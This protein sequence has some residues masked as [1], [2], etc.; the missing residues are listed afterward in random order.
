MLNINWDIARK[1]GFRLLALDLFMLS[2]ALIN[3]LL[4]AFDFT[5][6]KFRNFYYH[7]IPIAIHYDVVKGIE[8][9][10]TTVNY[11]KEAD[12]F[13]ISVKND[14]S[15]LI[16]A[17]SEMI[18]FSNQL[19]DEQPFGR[20][21]KVGEFELVKERM[22]K[23]VNI[24]SSKAAFMLFWSSTTIDNID[25]RKNFFDTKIKRVLETNYWRGIDYSGNYIDY[26]FYIDGI[27][28]FI[29]LIEFMTMWIYSVKIKG[30]EEKIL[31]PIYH[32]HDLLGCIPLNSFRILRLLRVVTIF[33]RLVNEGVISRDSL[34]YTSI[35]HRINKYKEILNADTSS[36]ISSDIL[37]DIQQDIKDG[38][39][40]D[41][42]ERVLK[43]HKKSIQ[44]VVVEN[45]KKI[46]VKIVD[47]NRKTIVDFLS[48]VIE[49]T[50]DDLPQYKALMRIPYVKDKVQ[51]L[52]SEESI[53]KFL[54]QSTISFSTSL[55]ETLN[56]RL[57]HTL[58]NNIT[59]DLID[60]IIL[61]L[62]N[63]E[64][65]NLVKDINENILERLII[66]I[67]QKRLNNKNK[68]IV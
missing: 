2:V 46:E 26:F 30:P 31:Y 20:S 19:L 10:T 18:K 35:F 28:V 12:K 59:E 25:E 6:L 7:Y 65:Q 58:L 29:F 62:E 41:L 8:P 17:Q 27:F 55:R 38:A 16:S 61:T 47:E 43:T 1:K 37:L 42:L 45:I 21:N 36:R 63:P 4:F 67:E 66:G 56:S 33:M 39:N 60:E 9:H 53:N 5:Y 68:F 57:G 48:R 40:K 24:N 50:I 23:E 44:K 32:L 54:N 11:L 14:S 3:L 22:R 34:I 49:D 13:F 52:L 64:T 15:N 51:D